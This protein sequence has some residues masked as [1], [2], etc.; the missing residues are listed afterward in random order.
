MVGNSPGCTVPA[1]LSAAP[2]TLSVALSRV[3][4][5]ESGVSFS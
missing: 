2:V 4:F 3:D 1:M 5:C